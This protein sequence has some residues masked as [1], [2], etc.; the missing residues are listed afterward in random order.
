MKIGNRS[1]TVILICS[2]F[3]IDCHNFFTFM[4]NS[5]CVKKYFKANFIAL[6]TCARCSSFYYF[7]ILVLI[8]GSYSLPHWQAAIK[9]CVQHIWRTNYITWF[10]CISFSETLRKLLYSWISVELMPCE[11]ARGQQLACTCDGMPSGEEKELFRI[12]CNKQ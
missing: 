3:G 11:F 4:R 9:D 10:I 12:E 2:F 6:I 1:S 7:I 8:R 5:N